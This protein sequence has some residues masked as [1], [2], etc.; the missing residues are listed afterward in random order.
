MW[1]YL[2]VTPF[3]FLDIIGLLSMKVFTD[4]PLISVEIHDYLARRFPDTLPKDTQISIE[5][6]RFLQGQQ[7]V[8]EA[9]KQLTEFQEDEE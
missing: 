4:T 8:I 2:R 5:S 7:S 3:L 1:G 9:I 6:I